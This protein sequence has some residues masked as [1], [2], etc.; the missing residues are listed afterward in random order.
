MTKAVRV[1]IS[2]RVQGVGYRQWCAEEARRRHLAGW[3]RNRRDGTVEAALAGDAALV[4]AMLERIRQGPPGSRVDDV[5]IAPC[6]A[7]LPTRF[8]VRDTA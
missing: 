4:D 3:V 7:T 5:A 8:E 1:E 2:G 6:E